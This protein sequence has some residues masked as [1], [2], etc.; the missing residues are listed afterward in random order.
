[1]SEAWVGFVVGAFVLAFAVTAAMNRHRREHR[2]A[3]LLRN[4]DHHEWWHWTHPS[5]TGSRTAKR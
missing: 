1:M 2:R 5:A 3:E 4:L